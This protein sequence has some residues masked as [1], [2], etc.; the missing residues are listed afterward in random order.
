MGGFLGNISR[1]Y[2]LGKVKIKAV[3]ARGWVVEPSA[4]NMTVLLFSKFLNQK[5]VDILLNSSSNDRAYQI[6]GRM[7]SQMVR[8]DV[9][10][11]LLFWVTHEQ[12]FI[13]SITAYFHLPTYLKRLLGSAGGFY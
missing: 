4:I 11:N 7:G 12:N 2:E 8:V 3:A 9:Y 5:N 13:T 1:S 6:F 10:A